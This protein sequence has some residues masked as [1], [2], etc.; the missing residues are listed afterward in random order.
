M[1]FYQIAVVILFLI[2]IIV[3]ITGV[4][5]AFSKNPVEHTKG[6]KM[7]FAGIISLG[8]ILLIGN[9]VCSGTG[10]Q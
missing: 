7:L 4:V 2:A 9:S 5:L 8:I 10:T 6:K 3:I 1:I